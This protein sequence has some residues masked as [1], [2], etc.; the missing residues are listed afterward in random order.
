MLVV[1]L[2]I[3]GA[4]VASHA[5]GQQN[6]VF[7]QVGLLTTV[8]LAAKNAILIVEFAEQRRHEGLSV[9]EAVFAAA[10]SRLRPVLMT[11]VA[12]IAGLVPLAV[13][14][15]AGAVGNRTIGMAAIGGMATG[16]VFGLLLVPG[17]YV[18]V[19]RG[20]SPPPPVAVD[21]AAANDE[22]SD[23]DQDATTNAEASHDV[24]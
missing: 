22:A 7:F 17:L 11:S 4:L 23:E 10:R 18:I 5:G 16:T 2:G 20:R 15:G 6:D 8:G 1:P 13:A 3:F 19:R 12:F 14:S 21:A 9:V 24:V